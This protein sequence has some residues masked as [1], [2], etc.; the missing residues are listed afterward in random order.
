MTTLPDILFDP[1]LG[2]QIISMLPLET[3]KT[4]LRLMYR[5][6][7]AL[8]RSYVKLLWDNW[9]GVNGR[10]RHHYR[11]G[12]YREG[13]HV[14]TGWGHVGDEEVKAIIFN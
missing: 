10:N 1:A 12:Y 6:D 7:P 4:I 14:I 2:P 13:T 3:K 11:T 9:W 5:I 8:V